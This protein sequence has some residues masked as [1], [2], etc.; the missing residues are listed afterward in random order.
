MTEIKKAAF[1]WKRMGLD[2]V[3]AAEDFLRRQQT[4]AG[5][6]R[7]ILP[8]LDIRD[9]PPVDR[10]AGVHRRLGGHGLFRRRHPPGL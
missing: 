2:T 7:D 3:E 4:L 9:R 10:G 8:L 5:R 1:R 6:E